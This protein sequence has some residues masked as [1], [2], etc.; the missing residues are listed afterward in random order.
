M[1]VTIADEMA[2][3]VGPFDLSLFAESNSGP[4]IDIDQVEVTSLGD[5]YR[6]F[7]PGLRNFQWAS[8]GRTDFDN[9][10][11]DER[12][13]L[14]ALGSNTPIMVGP[15]GPA[16]GARCYLAEGVAMSMKV[17]LK[18]GETAPYDIMCQ[19]RGRNVSRGRI[20]HPGATTRTTSGTGSIVQLG[21]VTAAQLLH[22]SLHVV[23]ASGTTPTL[24]V[25]VQSAAVIGFGSPTDRITFT[26]AAGITTAEYRTVAGAI[27]DQFWR[28][29]WAVTGGSPNYRFAV[30]VGIS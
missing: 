8:A 20:M 9:E 13:G 22:A 24:V 3:Y 10:N 7:L 21:A 18:V 14:S 6:R 28:V 23:A 16:D 11:I 5:L 30:G 1:A 26:T 12:L 17:G 4:D 2:L 27:A 25:K 15:N 29:T 19:G